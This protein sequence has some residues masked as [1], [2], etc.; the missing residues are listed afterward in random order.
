MSGIGGL[1]SS[2]SAGMAVAD[3]AGTEAGE[4]AGWQAASAIAAARMEERMAISVYHLQ[5]RAM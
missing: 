5:V 1:A 3:D 2:G 4:E